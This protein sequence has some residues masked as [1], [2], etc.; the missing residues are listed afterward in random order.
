MQPERL[1]G[2]I[3]GSMPNF[4]DVTGGDFDM[5]SLDYANEIVTS[6]N[7]HKK[8][9]DTSAELTPAFEESDDITDLAIWLEMQ[10]WLVDNCTAF[11]DDQQEMN[12]IYEV[13][14]GSNPD[15]TVD[16]IFPM[17]TLSSWG[18]RSGLSKGFRRLTEWDGSDDPEWEY[19]NIEEGDIFG[20]WIIEDLQQ[21]LSYLQWTAKATDLLAG[22]APGD[23]NKSTDTK[24]ATGNGVSDP[25][26]RADLALSWGLTGWSPDTTG[27]VYRTGFYWNLYGPFI[28][29]C[30]GY[31]SRG[32]ATM[33]DIT[34]YVPAVAEIYMY[35]E[36]DGASFYDIDGLGLSLWTSFLYETLPSQKATFRTSSLIGDIATTPDAPLPNVTAGATS[37]IW[38]WL[39]KWDW[40]FSN[41]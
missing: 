37:Y 13:L 38:D 23:G 11:V 15:F 34:D 7:E 3:R 22:G 28:W 33:D 17:L 4:T 20:W 16:P 29:T 40:S 18:A 31:R 25:A 36:A 9:V 41:V 2:I 10:E 35:P 8:V 26:A 14:R 12:G 30:Q 21:G 39:F 6:F 19:G 5:A 24:N 32:Y 1:Y 27:R